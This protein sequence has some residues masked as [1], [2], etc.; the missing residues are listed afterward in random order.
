MKK[1][2]DHRKIGTDRG[3]KGIVPTLGPRA[4]FGTSSFEE[5]TRLLKRAAYLPLFSMPNPGDPDVPISVWPFSLVP[6]LRDLIL[7]G[8]HVNEAPHRFEVQVE[9]PSPARGLAV[10]HSVGEQIANIHVH[11]AITPENFEAG[12]GRVPPP[13]LLIPFFSQRFSFPQGE[14]LFLD[15]QKSGFRGFGAGRTFPITIGGGLHLRIGAVIEVLEGFGKFAGLQGMVVVNGEIRP[16]N[17]LALFM[18]PRIMDPEGVL[19]AASPINPPVLVPDPDPTTAFFFFLGEVDADHPI[20]LNLAGDGRI[21]SVNLFE[22]LRLVHINFDI[23]TTQ[24]IRS[25]MIE[26]DVVGSHRSTLVFNP[27]APTDVTPLYSAN[28]IYTFHD[29]EGKTI[30]TVNANI[31]EG[32]A[33][34]T[35]LPGMSHT[36]FRIGGAGP[37]IEGTGQFMGAIGMASV[38]GALSLKPNT[39]SSLYMLR[40]IDPDSRFRILANNAWS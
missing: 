2:R 38:N 40:I 16:P 34:R 11:F 31:A 35:E 7:L 28:D 39:L 12:P 9:E 36:V 10:R 21:L 20:T 18:M 15:S 13:T 8:M 4:D 22:R 17:D 30:G 29:R 33:I 1:E 23:N 5:V 37:F 19:Q 32:R 3:V 24:D 27:D 26:G 25:R 6:A 14:F